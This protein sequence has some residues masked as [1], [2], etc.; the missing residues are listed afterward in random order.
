MHSF[1]AL[2]LYILGGTGLG[3][4]MLLTGLPAAPLIGAILGAGLLS[5]SGQIDIAYWPLGTKTA[6]GIGVGTVIIYVL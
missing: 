6:L 4:L 5:I 3:L 2:F 1:L